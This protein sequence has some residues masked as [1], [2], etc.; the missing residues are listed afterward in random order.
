MCRRA[1]D[2]R[3]P[4]RASNDVAQDRQARERDER[5]AKLVG[6]TTVSEAADRAAKRNTGEVEKRGRQQEA[7]RIGAGRGIERHL[8][9]V[10]VA[11]EDRKQTHDPHGNGDRS[12]AGERHDAAEHDDRGGNAEFDERQREPSHAERGAG[13]HDEDESRGHEPERAPAELPSEDTDRHH[14]Q[15]VVDPPDRTCKTPNKTV[16][17]TRTGMSEGGGGN[18]RE[19]G[20]RQASAHG[21]SPCGRANNSCAKLHITGVLDK[22]AAR[23]DVQPN[24]WRCNLTV[25]LLAEK[26]GAGPPGCGHPGGP[27][28]RRGGGWGRTR[29]SQLV[30]PEAKCSGGINGFFPLL[31]SRR[32]RPLVRLVAA[33]DERVQRPAGGWN[34][35]GFAPAIDCYPTKKRLPGAGAR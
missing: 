20:G 2:P 11:M 33:G 10:D 31:P 18:E 3:A 29:R 21:W 35:R 23:A 27:P 14:R 26:I 28:D 7:C 16:Q 13:R 5:T 4:L 6:G 9:T 1:H 22:G 25:S 8:G 24:R 30:V 17:L 12:P 15:N 34:R 32:L 19:G